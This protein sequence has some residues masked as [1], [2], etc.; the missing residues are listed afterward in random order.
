MSK[1]KAK[2]TLDDRIAHTSTLIYEAGHVF[3]IIYHNFIALQMPHSTAFDKSACAYS[4]GCLSI[5]AS[6]VLL[7]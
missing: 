1:K 2:K 6:I 5:R 3:R 4:N 7:F